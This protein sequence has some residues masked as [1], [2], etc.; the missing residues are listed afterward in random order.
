VGRPH[1]DQLDQRFSVPV[2]HGAGEGRRWRREAQLTHPVLPLRP[3]FIG[4]GRDT[5]FDDRIARVSVRHD[6]GGREE[7]IPVRVV[8]MVM[9][10]DHAAE[11]LAGG[12]EGGGFERPRV[13]RWAQRIDGE[14]MIRPDDHASVAEA[15]VVDAGSS[16]LRVGVNAG[17]ELAQF[18]PPTRDRRKG[19]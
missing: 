11:C 18:R 1:R 12:V 13:H 9:G 5:L 3:V 19:R 14:E 17:R 10:V 15:G 4:P 2:R 16:R 8:A 6:L 7:A